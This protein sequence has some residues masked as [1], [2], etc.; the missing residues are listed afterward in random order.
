MTLAGFLEIV[1]DLEQKEKEMELFWREQGIAGINDLINIRCAAIIIK[2]TLFAVSA[3]RHN[4]T[5]PRETRDSRLDTHC[6]LRQTI[7]YSGQCQFYR[8]IDMHLTVCIVW[9]AV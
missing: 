5:F 1:S 8:N 6:K 9:S 3:F 7:W 2:Y 4:I